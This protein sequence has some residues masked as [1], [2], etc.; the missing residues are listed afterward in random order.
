MMQVCTNIMISD[1]AASVFGNKKL[2]LKQANSAM[3]IHFKDKVEYH[4]KTLESTQ[5]N[6]VD[7]K[8]TVENTSKIWRRI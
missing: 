1:S 3:S 7:T 2:S 8:L 4:K 6:F 5:K